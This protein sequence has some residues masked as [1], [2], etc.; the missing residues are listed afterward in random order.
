MDR[1]KTDHIGLLVTNKYNNTNNFKY[2]VFITPSNVCGYRQTDISCS[3]YS[4]NN[5]TIDFIEFRNLDVGIKQINNLFRFYVDV[6]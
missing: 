2:L 5:K 4:D 6:I 1:N 3:L